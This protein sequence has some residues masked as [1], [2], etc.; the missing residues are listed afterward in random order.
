MK[1]IILTLTILVFFTAQILA[2]KIEYSLAVAKD[3]FLVCENI[4]CILTVKNKT[5]N[6]VINVEIKLKWNLKNQSMQNMPLGY[7]NINGE[8]AEINRTLIP[9]EEIILLTKDL[10]PNYGQMY[11][12]NPFIL[13]IPEGKYFFEVFI[14][15][16]DNNEI[17]VVDSFWVKYPSG[18]ER[19]VLEKFTWFIDRFHTPDDLNTLYVKFPNSVYAMQI[20]QQIS[21]RYMNY[22]NDPIKDKEV[23]KILIEDY[24]TFHTAKTVKN[25]LG[26]IENPA[27]RAEIFNKIKMRVKGTIF[28]K[29]YDQELKEFE[30]K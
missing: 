8:E 21:S 13:H 23:S 20:L 24:P 27:V 3:T 17:T 22:F 25:Y 12:K 1:K 30:E 19:S 16:R 14:L 9:D 2:Q 11:S 7:W 29:F 4:L 10:I 26:S 6:E 28:E 18:D 5:S 15:D